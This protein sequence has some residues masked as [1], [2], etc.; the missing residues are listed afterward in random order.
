ML[1]TFFLIP[2]F[3]GN[4]FQRGVNFGTLEGLKLLMP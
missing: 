4:Q 3:V 1:K 2:F